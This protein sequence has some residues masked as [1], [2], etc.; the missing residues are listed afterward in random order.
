[1]VLI[2]F[3]AKGRDIFT[4]SKISTLQFLAANYGY[5]S[6]HYIDAL[7]KSDIVFSD[8]ANTEYL[9]I[10]APLYQKAFIPTLEKYGINSSEFRLIASKLNSIRMFGKILDKKHYADYHELSVHQLLIL[11]N[12]V[13]KA[14]E[15]AEE[16]LVIIHSTLDGEGKYN[17]AIKYAKLRL[18]VASAKQEL[19][20]NA[21]A[22]AL[23]NCACL[24]IKANRT[25]DYSETISKLF[26]FLQTGGVSNDVRES[27]LNTLLNDLEN[28][29]QI[30]IWESALESYFRYRENGG[31]E[32]LSYPL[33]KLAQ[34]GDYEFLSQLDTLCLNQYRNE[35]MVSIYRNLGNYCGL[36]ENIEAKIYYTTK[37][38]AIAKELGREDLL[39]YNTPDGTQCDYMSLWSSYSKMGNMDKAIDALENGLFLIE[40]HLGVNNKLWLDTARMLSVDISQYRAD[41]GREI[42]LL[43][44]I[45]DVQKVIYGNDCENVAS[46]Y[47]LLIG[48]LRNAHKYDESIALVNKLLKSVTLRTKIGN[49]KLYNQLGLLYDAKGFYDE[50][51]AMFDKAIEMSGNEQEKA[52]Y[53]NN[54]LGSVSDSQNTL[55]NVERLKKEYASLDPDAPDWKRFRILEDIAWS[56]LQNNDYQ[57]AYDYYIKANNFISGTIDASNLVNHYLNTARVASSRYI[58]M[59]NLREA[60][61]VYKNRNLTDSVMLGRIYFKMADAYADARDYQTADDF[62]IKAIEYSQSLPVGNESLLSILNNAAI[63]LNSLRQNGQALRLQKIVCQM[64]ETT[65]GPKHPLYALSLSNIF[66]T[67]LELDSIDQAERI[68]DRYGVVTYDEHNDN[69]GQRNLLTLAAKLEIKKQNYEQAKKILKEELILTSDPNRRMMILSNLQDIAYTQRN[70]NELEQWTHESIS[71]LRDEII[72]DFF[73]LTAEERRNQLFYLQNIQNELIQYL[74]IAPALATDAFDFSLF[75]KGLLYHTEVEKNKIFQQKASKCDEY[76]RYQNL[77]NRLADAK[78]TGDSLAVA[79]LQKEVSILEADLTNKFVALKQLSRKLDISAINLD[80]TLGKDDL[81]IDFVRYKTA[82][83]YWYGAYVYS[84]RMAQPKFIP[85]VA[86]KALQDKAYDGNNVNYIFYYDKLNKGENASMIWDKLISYFSDY[87]DIYFCPDGLLNSLAIEY[88][89]D[90]NGKSMTSKYRLHRVFHLADINK[91]SRMGCNVFAIG[92]QDYNSPFESV[93]YNVDR[94]GRFQNLDSVAAE[95]KMIDD[96]MAVANPHVTHSVFINDL[97]RE[98]ALKRQS[99]TN[100]SSLHIAT[101][102]FY[103]SKTQLEMAFEN[104]N[105]FNHNVAVRALSANKESISGLVFRKGNLTWNSPNV[106]NQNDD[107]LTCEEIENLRFPSL[108]LTVLSACETGLGDIDSDGVWGL[109]RS[110]R[111]AGTKSLICSLCTVDDIWTQRLMKELYKLLSQGN[112][113]YNSFHQAQQLIQQEVLRSRKAMRR[114]D[115]P[116]LWTSFILIE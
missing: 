112:T 18:K 50:A 19:D 27:T 55:D 26:P 23:S 76:R 29:R 75:A 93:E 86:E 61:I 25:K 73:D 44:R 12:L 100:L 4:E 90:K 110:F 96:L 107:V 54:K 74:E 58:R 99:D 42:Q 78:S 22:Y 79:N 103:L 97:A 70:A 32:L 15:N 94:G 82:E 63:N 89:P 56:Y 13:P 9:H 92:V 115:V 66:H 113:V 51:L 3:Q 87:T 7:V 41:Y 1:M 39:I 52:M 33:T 81:A 11:K 104:E 88:L 17:E 71:L 109:Q 105:D 10:L 77:R 16:F 21:Y 38:I 53:I 106:S 60:E 30:D 48:A 111:I 14:T 8:T 36:T 20:P 80:K 34:N 67:Y 37:A 101:H 84:N 72:K 40:K 98:S 28:V 46:S 5:Y 91:G 83:E 45:I 57:N 95:L 69:V 31:L 114:K 108:N 24:Y 102:G 116:K 64:R 49:A 35:E 59:K 65:L 47:Y 43:K 85:I 68:L 6:P 62:Y 2:A